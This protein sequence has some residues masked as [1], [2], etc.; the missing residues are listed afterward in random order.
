M[1][2]WR[3]LRV[4]LHR[5]SF[6]PSLHPSQLGH[7]QRFNMSGAHVFSDIHHLSLR[8]CTINAANTVREDRNS[9]LVMQADDVDPYRSTSITFATE[10]RPTRS[11][12]SCQ[13][14]AFDSQAGWKSL[15]N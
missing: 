9:I 13:I 4:W 14:Q 6:L 2:M 3:D 7:L 11:F 10:E 1:N 5:R 15:P 12:P 8:D